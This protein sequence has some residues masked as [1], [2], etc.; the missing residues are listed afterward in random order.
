MSLAIQSALLIFTLRLIDI[1]FYTLRVIMLIHGRKKLTWVFAF[2]QSIVFV[3]GIRI[4][5]SGLDNWLNLL[6]F[7]AGFATGLVIGMLVEEQL[8]IGHIRLRI[9][10]PRY[11]EEITH[12]LRASGYAVTEIF[13][14]GKDGTVSFLNCLIPRREAKN[15]T[16]LIEGIDPQAFITAQFVRP[17]WRGFWQ[18][19]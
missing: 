5:L 8:G 11:G 2:C 3:L 13:G 10:S 4:V 14:Q 17:I 12:T 6:G 16:K 7:A 19:A 18:K 9:I 15:V 1:S